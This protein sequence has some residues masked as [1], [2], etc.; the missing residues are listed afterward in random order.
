MTLVNKEQK[1]LYEV[2]AR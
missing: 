1:T 2:F